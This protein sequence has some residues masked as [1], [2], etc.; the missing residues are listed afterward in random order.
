MIQR[1]GDLEMMSR[2]VNV[3]VSDQPFARY[4]VVRVMRLRYRCAMLH[5]YVCSI[6]FVVVPYMYVHVYVFMHMGHV[7]AAQRRDE[8]GKCGDICALT[9]SLTSSFTV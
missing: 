2:I 5:T 8:K 3:V 7:P 9:P 1:T 6:R 4:V